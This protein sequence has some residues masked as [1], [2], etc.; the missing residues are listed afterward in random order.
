MV[1]F[2]LIALLKNCTNV[3]SKVTKEYKCNKL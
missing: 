2:Y 1:L 3:N